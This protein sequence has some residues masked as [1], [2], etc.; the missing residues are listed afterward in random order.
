[1]MI[2]AYGVPAAKGS[3]KCIGARGGR[4]HQLVEVN[5]K[6]IK[7]WRATVT[8][9]GKAAVARY[10]PLSG[11]LT[12]S[13]VFTVPR[14]RRCRSAAAPG[15]PRAAAATSTNSYASSSTPSTTPACTATTRP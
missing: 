15:Q 7:P 10:G 13:A 2:K 4:G 1:M 9:A 12:V 11:P 5:A 6:K 14:P 3:M 8:A